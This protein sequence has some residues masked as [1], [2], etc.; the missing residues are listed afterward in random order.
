[1]LRFLKLSEWFFA[2]SGFALMFVSALAAPENAFG[3]AVVGGGVQKKVTPECTNFPLGSCNLECTAYH[4]VA[5]GSKGQKI[6]RWYCIDDSGKE[7]GTCKTDAGKC[8]ACGCVY[9][10]F[11]AADMGV[12]EDCACSL[13]GQ[14]KG[15]DKDK[16]K[17]K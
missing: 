11:A 4:Q 2:C 1:M 9:A 15:K 5:K 13:L 12:V 6:D 14:K 10:T 16:G 17:D 3:V 8:D 7:R